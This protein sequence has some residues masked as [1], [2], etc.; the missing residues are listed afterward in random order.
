M[1]S[2]VPLDKQSKRQ[3]REYYSRQRNTWNGVKPVT[4]AVPSKVGYDRKKTKDRERRDDL[5]N[6]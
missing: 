6:W 1:R 5:Y 4:K 2:F 3:Q